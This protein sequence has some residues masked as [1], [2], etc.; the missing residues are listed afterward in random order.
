MYPLPPLHWLQELG[1]CHQAYSAITFTCDLS[2]K[3]GIII[4]LKKKKKK[5]KLGRFL[6]LYR[7]TT[8]LYSSQNKNKPLSQV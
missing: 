2:W 4:A 1:L 7:A 5:H 8:I 6:A 3:L